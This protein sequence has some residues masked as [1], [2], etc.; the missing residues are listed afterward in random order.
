[1]G[2][3]VLDEMPN[4]IEKIN[5]LQVHMIIGFVLGLLTL[6]RIFVKKNH[7][8]LEPLKVENKAQKKLIK[9]THFAL[10]SLILLIFASG[11]TLSIMS[12]LGEIVSFGSSAPLPE[13]FGIYLSRNAHSIFA[14]V[15]FVFI[16]IHIVGVILYKLKTDSSISKRMWFGK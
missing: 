7:E 2:T 10:Y 12:G 6:I 8:P 16:A 9:F 5:Y 13:D 4:N 1:M 15:L 11:I 3:L 14:K